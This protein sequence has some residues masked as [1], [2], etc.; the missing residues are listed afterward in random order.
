MYK[1][2]RE[3][4]EKSDMVIAFLDGKSKGT[5]KLIDIAKKLNKCCIIKMI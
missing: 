3:M 1:T 5:K 2:N 4:V